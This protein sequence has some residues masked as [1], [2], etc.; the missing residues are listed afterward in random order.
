[1]T[2]EGAARKL[3]RRNGAFSR[4][5]LP[6][7][8]VYLCSFDFRR[9]LI[10]APDMDIRTRSTISWPRRATTYGMASMGRGVDADSGLAD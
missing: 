10:V 1:M 2:S 5:L 3:R 7:T 6:I 4:P 9:A 8:E